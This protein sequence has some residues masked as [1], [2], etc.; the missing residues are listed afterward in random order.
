P[1]RQD[2]QGLPSTDGHSVLLPP[3]RTVSDRLVRVCW[4]KCLGHFGGWPAA[5]CSIG[6]MIAVAA[7][8]LCR[9]YGRRWALMDVSFE[10]PE[11]ALVM[12]AGRNGSGKSTLLRILATA[13]R[14]DRGTIHILGQDAR[15]DRERVRQDVALLDHH[16]HL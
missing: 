5:R 1:G 13:I 15:A 11:G 14:A 7:A 8:G 3:R 9:R 16:T 10:L 4:P 2:R 12:V 6:R